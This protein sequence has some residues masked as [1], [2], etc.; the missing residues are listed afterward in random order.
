MLLAALLAALLLTPA[1][2]RAQTPQEAR[3]ELKQRLVSLLDQWE[4]A[5]AAITRLR[6]ELDRLEKSIGR[7][8]AE[9]QRLKALQQDL[10]LRLP[11]VLAEEANLKARLEQQQRRYHQQLRALYLLGVES[12]QGLMASE[13]DYRRV[14]AR[15]RAITWLVAGQ[16]QRLM[17]LRTARRRL[18]QVQGNLALKQ[19][20]LAELRAQVEDARRRL[21]LLFTQRS[22]LLE[23]LQQ[24]R[25]LLIER[26]GAIKEAEAR[27]ARAFALPPESDGQGA[28]PL[29]GVRAARGLLSP[30]VQGRVLAHARGDRQPGVTIQT[31][32]GAPVRAPWGGRVAFAGRLG[33]LGK[34]V[35]LYHGEK[36][37][38][39]LGHLASLAVAVGQKVAPGEVVGTV[40]EAG[41]LYLEVRLETRPVD[42]RRWLRLGS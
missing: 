24:R 15:S 4:T 22:A 38:T 33:W 40:G 31:W 14:L 12:D 32:G 3:H 35:V 1:W 34:V 30:P 21:G 28:R 23:Q 13:G 26:I 37:H 11:G 10:E 29:P 39:V 19:N 18:T 17:D 9:A 5:A 36:V 25:L 6:H 2:A 41:R 16:H 42:P 20:Q 8:Q 27:L 7:E